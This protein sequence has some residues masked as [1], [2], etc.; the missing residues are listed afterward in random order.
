MEIKNI[1]INGLKSPLGF[2]MEDLRI[3]WQVGCTSGKVPVY[4]RAELFSETG[5]QLEKQEGE[6]NPLCT[7]FTAPLSPRTRYKV[8]VYVKTDNGEEATGETFFETSKMAEPW[9]GQWIKPA[10]E[11]AIQ[12]EAEEKDSPKEVTLTDGAEQEEAKKAKSQK[13]ENQE[14]HPLFMKSFP[15]HGKLT[16]ARLYISGLGLYV[17]RLNGEKVG[18]ECLTPYFSDYHTQIQYQTYDV[19]GLLKEE[20]QLCVELGNG[21]YK[22]YFGLQGKKNLYGSEFALLC[23]LRLT[24]EDGKEEVI[25]SDPSWSYKASDITCSGIYAGED[26]DRTAR[27]E[28]SNPWRSALPAQVEGKLMAR[29]SLPI[30]EKEVLPVKEVITTPAGETVL[31]FGQNFAGYVAFYSDLPKGHKVTLDFG[32]ILQ[33]GNF[34][35]DNYRS[36]RSQFHYTSGG[37]GE[38]VRPQFTYFGFRYCRVTGWQGELD[39]TLF[40]GIVLYSDLEQ[41][42]HIETGHAKL[43]R[44]FQNAL[45]GQ[46]SN[47]LDLPTDCPQRDE[48]LGWCGDAQVFSG[49]AC[50][51][52]FS[53]PFYHK[54]CNDLAVEQKKLGGLM[55]GV[56]PVLSP[57]VAFSA[58]WG[59]IA[60]FLPHTLYERYGDAEAL[61]KEYPMMKAW[62]DYIDAQDA[63]RG[64]QYLFNFSSQLGDWLALDG[65][66]EQSLQGSTDEYFIGSCYYSMSAGMVAEAAKVLGYKEDAKY[67]EALQKNIKEAVLRD[68]YTE[69]GRLAL[70]TQTAY[71]VALYCGI[72]RDKELV[73]RALKE[74]FYKDCYKLKG[75]FVGAPI[76]CK[77]LAENG[78]MEEAYYFLLQEGYP[79]WLH[80][81]DLGATT[82]WERW[83]SVLD[84][85]LLSGTMMNSLN[86]Y[87][88]GAV[89]EFVYA[90]AAGIRP[91]APG[92]SRALLT[93]NPDRRLG[94]LKASY[95]SQSGLY[96]SEW[97][98][99]SDGKLHLLFEVPFGCTARA[100]LP[101]C[102]KDALQELSAGVHEFTYAPDRDLLSLYTTDT[103]IGDMMKNEE[104][105]KVIQETS[106]LLAWY[107][108]SGNTDYLY[109]S[110]TTLRRMF[111]MGF[112]KEEVDKLEKAVLA[113]R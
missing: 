105:A 40:Q 88:F 68:Y 27:E 112:T 56:I 58:V 41:T 78:M 16:R 52:L 29:L 107:L 91:L 24:Y 19:T 95:E 92:F 63:K 44:L 77:V 2:Y 104:A 66:T 39:P 12:E 1:R 71:V 3:S 45:W 101:F 87:A 22:G 23:E 81:V 37:Y 85:G 72:Y 30:L 70:D 94:W 4:S 13:D 59:D 36:A 73:K 9:E 79:G 21:W 5:E 100:E 83:N 84:N 113:L 96:R 82:I 106:P 25:A 46:K 15:V 47:F 67:Y 103:L 75:G 110:L 69:T 33:N 98:I 64:N 49:T 20:N 108:G 28:G 102:P 61:R 54:F 97:E 93:P 55:P 8:M 31:D 53:S 43:N 62:V 48:R 17:A 90:Y 32:E 111:F 50:Y 42:G 11:E 86:H 18:K 74:R 38:W 60:T 51:N 26:V 6:L 14:F 10:P 57:D 80:C 99:L 35:R 109:E 65:R 76:L 7:V 34:Y 89:M